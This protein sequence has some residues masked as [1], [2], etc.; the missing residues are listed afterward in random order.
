MQ[1]YLGRLT[2]E[3]PGKDW[4]TEMAKTAKSLTDPDEV[5]SRGASFCILHA[6][7]LSSGHEDPAVPPVNKEKH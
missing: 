4:N 2:A 6:F 3:D 1:F 5:L 7:S